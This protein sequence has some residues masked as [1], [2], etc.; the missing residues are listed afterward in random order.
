M[1][2]IMFQTELGSYVKAVINILHILHWKNIA[3]LYDKEN[4]VYGKC[5][6]KFIKIPVDN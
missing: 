5:T 3:I 2:L 6:F 1:L 4:I